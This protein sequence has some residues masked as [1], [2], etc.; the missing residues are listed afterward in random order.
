MMNLSYLEKSIDIGFRGCKDFSVGVIVVV[1]VIK[2]F[3]VKERVF[4]VII[5]V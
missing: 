4:N 5:F 2:D 3:V 1:I